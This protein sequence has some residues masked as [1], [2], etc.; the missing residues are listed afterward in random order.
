MAALT[1]ELFS[2]AP[3]R[4]VVDSGFTFLNERL[5]VRYG[6]SGV[7]GVAMRRVDLPFDS[8]HG[9]FMT[10]SSVLKITANGT[11]TSPVLRGK[12]IMD[13]ILGLP[14]PPKKASARTAS[15]SRSTMPCLS[16]P[17][18]SCPMAVHSRM[19]AT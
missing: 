11:T 13:R 5:A 10:Q 9:G 16:I 7:R 19:S 6:V 4:N 2:V 18:A 8:P 3:A 14:S 1:S 17:V 12:F 15:P